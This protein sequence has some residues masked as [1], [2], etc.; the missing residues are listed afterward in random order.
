VL[1]SSLFSARLEDKI[2][3]GRREYPCGCFDID[4]L[5]QRERNYKGSVKNP[6]SLLREIMK[7][8]IKE[9]SAWGWEYELP[10]AC[11]RV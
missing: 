2:A 6:E 10:E 9:E 7:T 11:R 1:S 3:E 4:L 8:F 5:F